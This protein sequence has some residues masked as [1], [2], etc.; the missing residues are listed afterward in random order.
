VADFQ[1]CPQLPRQEDS[2]LLAETATASP[3]QTLMKVGQNQPNNLMTGFWLV[4]LFLLVAFSATTAPAQSLARTN[5]Q[6]YFDNTKTE[7]RAIAA[8]KRL[9]TNVLVYRSLG[10]FEADGRLAR[11]TLQTFETELAKVNSE[12]GSLLAE[13]P[14]GKF[15]TEII[16]AFDSYRDG[17]FWWRQIDQPRVVHVSALTSEPRR[18][19]AD[20]NYRSTIPYTVAIHWRQAQK[21]LSQAEKTLGQ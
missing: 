5:Q 20:T 11:V 14:A 19:L 16:N 4:Q 15:R 10:Q 3:E 18:S 7:V 12:L 8:L 9:E 2:K 13:I 6:P 21:Y 1:I 17:V